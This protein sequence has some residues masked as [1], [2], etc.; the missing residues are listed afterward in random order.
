MPGADRMAWRLGAKTRVPAL[1]AVVG[2]C[3]CPSKGLSAGM[4]PYCSSGVPRALHPGWLHS[5]A[6]ASRHR[7][8]AASEAQ[9]QTA[10]HAILCRIRVSERGGA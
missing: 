4:D 6:T 10:G 2:L 7:D 1:G 9:H 3:L 8:P 5:G